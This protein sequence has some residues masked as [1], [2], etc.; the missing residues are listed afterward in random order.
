VSSKTFSSDLT[1][2]PALRRLVLGTGLAAVV[3][4]AA[5][6]AGLPFGASWRIGAATIWI[7]V[8]CRDLWVV[9]AGFRHCTRIRIEHT[10]NMLVYAT[11]NRCA[12]ATLSAGSVV[13]QDLAWLRF[14]TENGRRHVELFRRKTAQIKDWR[15]LQVI[16]RHLGAGA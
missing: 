7:L 1:P 12:V 16:W 11:D 8:C 4:G 15:R 3:G 10:G 2:E 5:A 6:I 13:L 14:R 9:L